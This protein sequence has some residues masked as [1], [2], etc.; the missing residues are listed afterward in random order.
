MAHAWRNHDISLVGCYVL[1]VVSNFIVPLKSA[2]FTIEEEES[3]WYVLIAHEYLYA[4]TVVHALLALFVLVLLCYFWNRETG[5]RWDP[6][7]IL[8]LLVLLRHSNFLEEFAGLDVGSSRAVVEQLECL[9]V[10]LGYW[11]IDEDKGLY[12]H[13]FGVVQGS[14]ALDGKMI[15]YVRFIYA[16]ISISSETGFRYA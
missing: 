5:L 2:L 14:V 8:D 10:R 9:R 6:V 16:N 7:S 4:L 1:L 3:A 13:G 15:D 12:W 11:I